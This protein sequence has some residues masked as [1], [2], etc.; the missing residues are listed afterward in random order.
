MGLLIRFKLIYINAVFHFFLHISSSWVELRLHAEFQL[1]ILLRS[2]RFM[3]GDKIK[4]KHSMK[5]MASLT[6]ARAVVEAG[7]VTKADQ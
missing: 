5:L 7:V 4:A 1:L 3:V 2:G 6:P